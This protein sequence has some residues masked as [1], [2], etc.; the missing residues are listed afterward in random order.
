MGRKPTNWTNKRVGML[1]PLYLTERRSG[2]NRYW[3]CKCDCGNIIEVS[4][5]NLK[6]KHV[7]S[8]GCWKDNNITNRRFDSLIALEPTN[9]RI[10]HDGSIVWKCLCDCGSICYKGLSDLK[11][12]TNN[13]CGCSERKRSKGEL[14]IIDILTENH[15]F[16]EQEKTFDSCRF[17]NNRLARFDFY[18]N[19]KYL[20]EF[21]GQQHETFSE[22]GW[23]TKEKVR[24]IQQRDRIK[25][26]WCK[27]NGIPLIRIPYT[28][29]NEL[30]LKDLLL[31][32]SKFIIN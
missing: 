18:V 16:F 29:L 9:K 14:K 24:K 20:I 2:G 4:A 12:S 8:C 21:D 25:N 22:K 6:S 28:H 15:I 11:T 27:K 31:E 13:S 3:M 10:E 5:S 17:D 32:T 23:F 7:T 1:T 30:E 19:N 26:Q